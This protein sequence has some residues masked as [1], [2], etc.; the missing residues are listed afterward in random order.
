M[1]CPYGVV[2]VTCSLTAAVEIMRVA[3]AGWYRYDLVWH[4]TTP[5]G[6]L[7]AKKAPLRNHELILIF[8]PMPLG[9]HTYNP[10]KTY[11]HAR[12]VSKASSKVRCKETELYG[13]AG[14][15]T[16]DSTERY[17]LSVMTFKTDKQKSAIHPNQK[18]V[19][20]LRHLIRTYTN[21]GDMV[22]DPVAGS[23]TTGIAAYEEGRDCLLIEKD[24]QF[25][26]DMMNRF[27]NNNIKIENCEFIC[28]R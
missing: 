6:F 16:Y 18:P 25:F 3:P 27:S 9:K 7:N 20:L 19:E 5:T 8:S 2:A 14:L 28:M 17:P 23:G 21:P 11:G 22:M 12:K 13:K 15:T 4:K 10:Q 26:E 24:P 1:L